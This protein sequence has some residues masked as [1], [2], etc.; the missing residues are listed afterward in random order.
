MNAPTIVA[1]AGSLRALCARVADADRVG[2][3]TEFHA[4][5]TYSPRLMVVQ[6]AFGDGAAIVDAV[7]L[8]NLRELAA[9]LTKTTVVGH[10]LS[11]DLKI[12]A[13]RYE[14]VPP[15]VFDTQIAAAFLGYGC[16]SRLQIS[17]VP[18]AAYVLRN[19]RP[20][21]IGRRARFQNGRSST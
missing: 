4:E 9:A 17:C 8:A 5:R 10:A 11:A 21:A 15:R 14:L 3:D 6:I 2:L 12:F 19:R 20:S 18:S 1:D 16:R 13:D 7:A